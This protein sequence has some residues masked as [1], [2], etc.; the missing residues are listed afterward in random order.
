MFLTTNITIVCTVVEQNELDF[1]LYLNL[2][3]RC[4]YGSPKNEKKNEDSSSA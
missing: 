1:K 2:K 3:D 4:T